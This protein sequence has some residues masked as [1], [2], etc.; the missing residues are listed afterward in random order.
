MDIDSLLFLVLRAVICLRLLPVVDLDK[1]VKLLVNVDF[2]LS[3]DLE[4]PQDGIR[5]R[6]AVVSG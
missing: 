6:A 1:L 3:Q 5:P 4:L 2:E